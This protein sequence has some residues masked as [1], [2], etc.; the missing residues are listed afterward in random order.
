MNN[1]NMMQVS[2]DCAPVVHTKVSQDANFIPFFNTVW[3]SGWV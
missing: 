3:I 1:A 2:T